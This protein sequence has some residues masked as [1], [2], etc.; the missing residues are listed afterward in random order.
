MAVGVTETAAG[1]TVLG[2]CGSYPAAGGACS[3]YL[4]DDGTT[5]LW[6]DAGSGTMANLQRHV[7]L[8]DVDALVLS[9]EHP[10]HWQ[11]LEG[12]VIALEHVTGRKGFPVY[13]PAGL[14]R[15]TYHPSEPWVA[16]HDVTDGDRAEVGTFSLTFSRTDH[17][18]ETLAVRID[19]AGGAFGY[20]ADTGPGW[21]LEALGPGLD[22]VLCEATVP[23]AEEGRLKHLS[24]RQ[25][26][27]SARAAGAGRLVLTHLWPSLDP[28]RSRTEGADAFGGP[29]EVAST[30]ARYPI[31]HREGAS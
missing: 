2:C 25:A 20:S 9:H 4:V 27:S 29:V 1:V 8:D 23:I 13:A 16:W 19:G 24:A 21:S 30:G 14:R 17:G 5:R 28:E 6:L 18:P 26:G 7:S 31:A 3:G 11:D 22:L 10:D 12:L 15:H